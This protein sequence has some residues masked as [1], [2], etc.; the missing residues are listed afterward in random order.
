MFNGEPVLP[1]SWQTAFNVVSSVGQFFG[2]FMCAWLSD[3]LGR[4]IGLLGG[5]IMCTGGI[6]GQI[7]ST[8][9]VAF[10]I[11]KLVLGFGLGFYLTI[12]PLVCSEVCHDLYPIN[13]FELT[14]D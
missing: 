8:T 6:F 9:R 2:G 11:S 14:H 13:I 10:L 1:A 5:V 4:K 12:G 7:F 3:R